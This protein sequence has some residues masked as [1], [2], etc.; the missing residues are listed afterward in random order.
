MK[1]DGQSLVKEDDGSEGLSK[2][3]RTSWAMA[4]TAGSLVN[5]K[6]ENSMLMLLRLPC[7]GE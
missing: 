5:F 2:G 1:T 4:L 7:L 6:E 3:S